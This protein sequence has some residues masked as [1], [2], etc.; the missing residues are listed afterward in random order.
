MKLAELVDIYTIRYRSKPRL[1]RAPGRINL[2]GG[3]TDYNNGF[4]LPA[5]IDKEIWMLMAPNKLEVCK[6][7]SHDFDEYVEF[8]RDDYRNVPYK[9]SKYIIGIIDQLSRKG[10]NIGGFDCVF[11]GDIPLGVGMAS[12]AALECA[13]VI[14]LNK[15]FDLKL[16]DMDMALMA[17]KA[18][19]EY[20]GVNCGIMDQFA[21][22]FPQPG[23][24]LKIDCQ[25]FNYEK[26]KI[27]LSKHDLVLI[28][29]MVNH[30]LVETEYNKRIAECESVIEKLNNLGHSFRTLRDVSLG[31]LELNRT[32]L[33]R[34]EYRRAKYIIE[35]SL[36][37]VKACDAIQ[38][39]NLKKAGELMYKSHDGLQFE[40]QVS[41]KE[42]DFLVD[43]TMQHEEVLGSRIMGKGH[44]GCTVSLIESA[45]ADQIV[46]EICENYL[47][48]FGIKP[49]VYPVKLASGASESDI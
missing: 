25:D 28:N 1:F 21:S 7:Y 12:S 27:D 3:H 43:A 2:I 20:V 33:E 41:C 49:E 38:E 39:N 22:I 26:V 42:L 31:Q 13:T 8:K 15:I 5:A 40:Y 44:G 11:A 29:P 36:R 24:L 32:K 35:E 18:E 14:G 6:I 48:Q 37:V 46:D 23:H 10:I 19:R 45:M 16:S 30:T 34:N 17:Q 9:W 4:V 47:L